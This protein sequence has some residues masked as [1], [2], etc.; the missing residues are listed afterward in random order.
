MRRSIYLSNLFVIALLL[1]SVS[2][3]AQSPTISQ[4]PSDTSVCPGTGISFTVGASADAGFTL[5]YQWLVKRSGSS[6][7]DTLTNGGIYNNVDSANLTITA[8]DSVSGFV[9]RCLVYEFD[10]TTYFYATSSAA[11]LTLLPLPSAGTLSGTTPICL[12]TSDTLMSTIT[13]G[14]WSSTDTRLATIDGTTGIISTVNPGTVTFNYSSTNSCGTA[15]VHIA[16]KIWSLPNA[17]MISG[18]TA[19]CNGSQITLTEDSTNGTWTSS[20]ISIATI[21]TNGIVST[22]MAGNVGIMYMVMDT[23]GCVNSANYLIN[24][25]SFLSSKPVNGTSIVC[26]GSYVALSDSD[27]GEMPMWSVTNGNATISTSGMLTGVAAGMD[28]VIYSDSNACNMVSA[29]PFYVTIQ[30]SAD[31]GTITG[32]N[33][34]CTGT[35]ISL[36][37]SISGGTWLSSSSSVAWVDGSGNVTGRTGGSTIISY[38][39]SNACGASVATDT[40]LVDA[41]VLPITGED[42]VGIGH[43]TTLY[44]ATPGGMWSA[45]T[46]DT[47][48]AVNAT[49]GVI[50]GLYVGESIVTYTDSNA[51]GMS[52]TSVTV[53]TGTAPFVPNILTTKDTVCLNGTITVRDTLPGGVFTSNSANASVTADG[54]VTGLVGLTFDTVNYTYTNAFGS[55]TVSVHLFINEPPKDSISMDTLVST[56]TTY[57]LSVTQVGGGKERSGVWSISSDTVGYLVGD[58][59]VYTDLVVLNAGRFMLKYI[60]YDNCGSDTVTKWFSTP[61]YNAV[62]NVIADNGNLSVFPNPNTGNFGMKLSTA[63]VQPASIVITNVLGAKVTEIS[64]MTNAVNNIAFDEPSGIYFINATTEDG[65]KYTTKMVISK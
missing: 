37:E 14:T 43:T 56:S 55:T 6:T 35:S 8:Q 62:N 29:P 24:V 50:T 20:N 58:G 52:S 18:P 30:T 38:L 10:T 34:L 47:L 54:I 44:D 33:E 28:T 25:D 49:T 42:S 12:G 40:V 4:N 5:G 36:T 23:N 31:A 59:G 57:A 63:H 9:Y 13:G 48:V 51:C 32:P 3:K 39:V 16:I 60:G 64:I 15:T 41:P 1:F 7:W 22:V 17:G 19:V 65:E 21:D 2:I 61:G 53:Y 46:A 45:A 27:S 11:T 26:V